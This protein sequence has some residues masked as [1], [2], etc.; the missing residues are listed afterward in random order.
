MYVFLRRQLKL[1]AVGELTLSEGLKSARND[2]AELT[3]HKVHASTGTADFLFPT[4]I[5]KGR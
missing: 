4:A 1:R 5:A 3:P 2:L